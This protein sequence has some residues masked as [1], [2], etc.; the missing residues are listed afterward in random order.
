M[1][2]AHDDDAPPLGTVLGDRYRLVRLIGSGAMGSVF[3][4][5]NGNDA[6]VAVKTLSSARGKKEKKDA[7]ERRARF[8][9]EAAVC[10]SLVHPNVVLVIDHGV[11][12]A[13]DAPFLVMPLLRGED[14][15]RVIDREGA[16]DPSVCV[17]I[18]VQA[19]RGLGAAHA[20]GIVHRDVKPS[21][22]FLETD[23]DGTV[24]VKVADFGLAKVFDDSVQSLTASGRFMGTPQYVSPEQAT[25][26][27]RVDERGDVWSL[28]M[29]LY[30]AMAGVPAFAHVRSFM[31]LVLEL[32]GPAGVPTL[33]R[34]AP[35]ID[36]AV[37]RVVHG[38]LI[39]E[40]ELRCPSMAELA[41]ALEMAAGVDVARAPIATS[42]VRG[43]S[44]ETRRTRADVAE[45]PASWD[46]LLCVR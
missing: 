45:L 12:A 10:R 16:L 20:R 3:E 15:A 7:P 25:N 17:A 9:R 43:V 13:T 18:F 22:L 6:H 34:T 42:A 44:D 46:D 32:T 8:L 24:V 11:D 37:A 14:L 40:L 38:A 30:H 29:S 5:T 23:A 31:A 19:C 4:A 36:P 28:A 21:N 26:A 2:L 39:R 27:K 1:T 35:W 41:L 33:Q